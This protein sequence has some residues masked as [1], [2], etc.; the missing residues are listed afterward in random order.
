MQRSDP[1][2]RRH[3]SS[4]ARAPEPPR[5]VE[6]SQ[7]GNG[8]GHGQDPPWRRPRADSEV[9]SE[10]RSESTRRAPRGGRRGTEPNGI[11]SSA[12]RIKNMEAIRRSAR[13][14]G[15]HTIADQLTTQITELRQQKANARPTREKLASAEAK[16][17]LAQADLAKSTELLDKA[18]ERKDAAVKDL[19]YV[20]TLPDDLR[21]QADEEKVEQANR[22]EDPDNLMDY[23]DELL[24]ADQATLDA[25]TPRIFAAVNA[26]RSILTGH[27]DVD[28]SECGSAASDEEEQDEGEYMAL[29]TASSRDSHATADSSSENGRGTATLVVT[30]TTWRPRSKQPR[31]GGKGQVPIHYTMTPPDSEDC[32]E[33]TQ[34]ED[35][36]RQERSDRGRSTAP[37]T[38]S[39]AR[40]RAH[41][42]G[43]VKPD[44]SRSPAT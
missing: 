41:S 3:T 40:P 29:E 44:R 42:A 2:R 19:A 14:A 1:S 43:A 20:G 38:S 37:S 15:E 6:R 28:N 31:T 17:V 7:R 10:T 9:R 12:D 23:F 34:S 18:Q 8:K 35:R 33:T 4:L 30:S 36:A 22:T 5:T 25:R 26:V 21:R 16:Y 11:A 13:K 27:A 32:M 24:D 39:R